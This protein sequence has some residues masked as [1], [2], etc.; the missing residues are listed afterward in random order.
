MSCTMGKV[1]YN[2]DAALNYGHAVGSPQLL[3][4]FTEHVGTIHRPPYDDWETC[5]T[6]G[7]TAALELLFRM[8]CNRG[9]LIVGV[10]TAARLT[11]V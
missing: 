11:A 5:L 6:S 9:D 4:F 7:T 3:R 8:L 2:L 1:A 10:S